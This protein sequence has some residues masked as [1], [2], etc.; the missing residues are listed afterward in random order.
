MGENLNRTCIFLIFF[1]ILFGLS[2]GNNITTIIDNGDPGTSFTGTWEVSSG[3]GAYGTDS[4][5]GRGGATYTWQTDSLAPGTYEVFM[6]WTEYTSRTDAAPVAIVHA[7][8]TAN[9]TVNQQTNGSQWNSLGTYD[10]DGTGAVTIT[11]LGAFPQNTCADAVRFMP[12]A[13]PPAA[14]N[15]FVDNTDPATSRV[16]TWEVSG[17]PDP[18]GTNSVYCRKPDCSFSWSFT[19]TVT[20]L[21]GVYMWWTEFA[22]RSTAAPVEIETADG[23]VNLIV[24]QQVYGGRWNWLGD[25]LLNAGTTYR[26]TIRTLAD[27]STV[28]ADAVCFTPPTET[29]TFSD[30]LIHEMNALSLAHYL[31]NDGPSSLPTTL[32]ITASGQVGDPP[33]LNTVTVNEHSLLNLS[34]R[35]EGG[36]VANDNSQVNIY[37]GAFCRNLDVNHNSIVNMYG[38]FVYGGEDIY[39]LHRV[40]L[41]EQSK[42]TLHDGELQGWVIVRDATFTMNGGKI[43]TI[44]N[45]ISGMLD[46]TDTAYAEINGGTIDRIQTFIQSNADINGGTIRLLSHLSTTGKTVIKGGNIAN[47][48]HGSATDPVGDVE[49][50]GTSFNYPFG[51]VDDLTGTITGTLA[52][53]DSLNMA[54]TRASAARIVLIES[55]TAETV[56]DNTD[57]NTSRVGTWPVSGGENPYGADSLYCRALNCSFSWLFTPEADGYYEVAM[58]WTEFTSR[59][60][61]A[62]VEIQTAFGIQYLT[63]NQQTNGGKW[64]PLGQYPFEAGQ[65]YSVTIRTLTDNTTVSADAVRLVKTASPP[66]GEPIVYNDGQTH[67]INSLVISDIEVSDGPSSQP[68]TLNIAATGEIGA[69]EPLSWNTVSVLEHSILNI[70]GRL[71]WGFDATDDSR[72]TMYSGYSYAFGVS[73]NSR[74]DIYGGEVITGLPWGM[75][76]AVMAGNSQVYLHDGS[77][78]TLSASETSRF[79][80]NGGTIREFEGGSGSGHIQAYGQ[81]QI[82]INAGSVSGDIEAGG[83]SQIEINGGSVG[84]LFCV[85]DAQAQINGGSLT[86][87]LGAYSTGTVTIKGGSVQNLTVGNEF[88]SAAATVE[89]Y[90]TA[91]NLP[92]GE[93]T[94][95]S[96]TITGTLENGDPL[97]VNFTRDAASKIILIES[98][99]P[100]EVIIDNTDANTSRVGTWAASGAVNPYGADSLWCRRPNGSFTWRF[101]PDESGY[102]DVSM[103]WTE[104]TSRS[105]AAPVEIVSNDGTSSLTVNQ[106]TDGGKWNLLGTYYFNAGVVY[107]VTVRTLTD[108]TTVC[109]DAVRFAKSDTPPPPANET[110]IDNTSSATERVGTWPV[111]GAAH[112]YGTNSVYCRERDCS[113]TWLFT[114]EKTA[115][116]EVA[117]WW[118]VISSRSSVAPVEIESDDGTDFLTVNQLADGG[119]WNVLGK[120]QFTQGTTYRVT[121]RTLTDKSSICADAMRFSETIAP[122]PPQPEGI[123]ID[124]TDANTEMVGKW[125][126]SGGLNPYG[127]NSVYCRAPDC[128]FTWRFTPDEDGY[129]EVFMYWTDS[130]SRSTAAPVTIE[131]VDGTAQL[132]VNQMA[133]CAVWNRLGEYP[134]YA[135]VTYRVTI[136]TLTDNSSVCADAVCFE[137]T[138]T[139]PPPPPPPPSGIIID[140]TDP[141][142]TYVGTWPVSGG[143][144]P[145][146]ADSL[147]CR[148]A[149]CSFTWLF[150]PTKSAFYEVSMWWTEFSSRSTVTPV[151]VQ[152]AGGTALM[153]VNQQTG[154]NAWNTL[155][156]WYFE[157]G[158]TYSVTVRTLPDRSAV[159]ADAVKFEEV[160][161]VVPDTIID[162][163]DSETVIVGTW[164]ASGGAN[165]YSYDSVYCRDSGR[166]F[167]WQFTPQVSGQ[168]EV[169]MWWTEFSSRSTAAPVR[170][171]HV[172]GTA[173]MTVDQQTDGGQWNPLGSYLF[174]AGQ[175]YDITIRTMTDRSTTCA[176]AVKLVKVP[177]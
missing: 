26:V 22:S 21:H 145:W 165:P 169:N 2:P 68:T 122:P 119:M 143:I 55:T 176:D 20:G 50:Y 42:M 8:G 71:S 57:A 94:N 121:I 75:D 95:T 31:L 40:Y 147:Y 76:F 17:A 46:L 112:P 62:P 7:G 25:H 83:Q 51:E 9:L 134:F 133:N 129:Y 137:K 87:G 100:E 157:A 174:E 144:N 106:Q 131:N 79:V 170:I 30:G 113:F 56:I 163:R 99:A 28:C 78:N 72:V 149:D 146:G 150:T 88:D 130:I 64:N 44:A 61:A 69:V 105:T 5:W 115:W 6:W 65:T 116:Y 53:G 14:R 120:Y 36:V 97:N 124:N 32:N 127:T 135:G 160:E 13:Q 164:A 3:T 125:P 80:M 166:S 177:D 103:W 159:C 43:T 52:N 104:F 11:G 158:T 73:G 101:T 154:G 84:N 141:N 107:S 102:Y 15:V 109:A 173:A 86:R 58:W 161:I 167:T 23:P 82:E 156:A 126:V 98:S 41:S 77:I 33:L 114:P 175:T 171:Q 110:I 24:D 27:N 39:G 117:M 18:Y 93:V 34:G 37:E 10:F 47:L 59:S 153:T 54:F 63:V 38:G 132:T 60:T 19:P 128:S 152:H 29:I 45:Q 35:A 140:N 142:T 151:E 162:N 16:G 67:E 136:Y 138:S 66:P 1:A 168:Y 108:N 74:L 91:F 172:E 89:I 92:F 12:A 81:S 123:F 111:S 118:T 139:P 49:I 85:D 148:T 155:D 48:E 4:L 70:W 96:G 90:G